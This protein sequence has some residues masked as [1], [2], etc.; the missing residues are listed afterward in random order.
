M[1][2][3]L[4]LTTRQRRRA[5]SAEPALAD[6]VPANWPDPLRV[7]VEDVNDVAMTYIVQRKDRFYVIA[8]D[9][10]DPLTGKERR[11]WRSVG[12]DRAEAEAIALRLVR[13]PIRGA[14]AE[15]RPDQLKPSGPP[16]RSCSATCHSTLEPGS[17]DLST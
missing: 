8:Y 14:G 7:G 11:R 15:G 6:G 9:G 2:P 13:G 4:A 12:H 1:L 16:S 3:R 10:I 5:R 17:A